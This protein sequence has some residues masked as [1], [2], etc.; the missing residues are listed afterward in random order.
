MQDHQFSLNRTDL[1][2]AYAFDSIGDSEI[3]GVNEIAARIKAPVSSMQKAL[4][5]KK[6]KQFIRVGQ[7]W[8]KRP[9]IDSIQWQPGE[10]E[11]FQQAIDAENIVLIR[12]RIQEAKKC[13]DADDAFIQFAT[14]EMRKLL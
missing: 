10:R 1:Y 13:R 9:T 11:E 12:K 8:K 6:N 5:H 3:L 2:L 14:E 7:K 4:N